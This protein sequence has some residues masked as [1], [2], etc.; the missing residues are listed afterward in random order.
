[1][2]AWQNNLAT[3]KPSLIAMPCS[4]LEKNKYLPNCLQLGSYADK[5]YRLCRKNALIGFNLT[6][7]P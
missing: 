4:L 3:G 6:L 5:H 2:E 7:A 1:M